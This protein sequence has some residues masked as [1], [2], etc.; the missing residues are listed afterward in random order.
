MIKTGG[1]SRQPSVEGDDNQ[2]DGV[3]E[4]ALFTAQPPPLG[5]A[6][7]AVVVPSPDPASPVAVIYPTRSHL[8]ATRTQARVHRRALPKNPIVKILKRQLRDEHADIAA[9][10]AK[11]ATNPRLPDLRTSATS[12][13]AQPDDG[14]RVRHGVVYR[15]ATPPFLDDPTRQRSALRGSASHPGPTCQLR[16]DR[17]GQQPATARG[18]ARAHHCLS[19]REAPGTPAGP[20]LPHRRWR[21]STFATTKRSAYSLATIVARLRPARAALQVTAPRQDR[22]RRELAVTLSAIA[23][24]PRR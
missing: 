23:V 4:F 17:G 5:V 8:P 19:G 3:S 2:L 18:R 13:H 6:V 16:R 12:R 20:R 9:D 11:T 21:P 7:L 24:G 15:S 1:R 14:R 22:N 10:G